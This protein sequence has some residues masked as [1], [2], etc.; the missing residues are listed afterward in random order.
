[1]RRR[2]G[3]RIRARRIELGRPQRKLAE[4]AKISEKYLSRIELG[5][6]TP[7]FSVVA[8]ITA[9]L[10]ITLDELLQRPVHQKTSVGREQLA[11]LLAEL[12]EPT[13]QHV[14]GVVR[15]VLRP[16]A[17]PKASLKPKRTRDGT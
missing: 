3:K 16:Y 11:A 13:L 14:V 7:S 10:E 12:D 15:E 9:A 8:R 5:E 2:L 4:A 6:V 17:K 1:M